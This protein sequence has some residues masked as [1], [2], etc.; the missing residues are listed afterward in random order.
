MPIFH[1]THNC[2]L[3]LHSSWHLELAYFSSS[4]VQL[5][6][7]PHLHFSSSLYT[8]KRQIYV[9]SHL[10]ENKIWENK[11]RDTVNLDLHVAPI[12]HNFSFDV[13]FFFSICIQPT[14]VISTSG[15][16]TLRI[17]W[18]ICNVPN[19]VPTHSIY[20][21]AYKSNICNSTFCLS[22]HVFRSQTMFSRLNLIVCLENHWIHNASCENRNPCVFAGQNWHQLIFPGEHCN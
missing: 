9:L 3:S 13:I 14:L 2:D 11:V 4:N 1:H 17:C 5:K 20:D 10:Q 22:R 6:I 21:F 8:D 12:V 7:R 18:R 15:I 19:S 16:P